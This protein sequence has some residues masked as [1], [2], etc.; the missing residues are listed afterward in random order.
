VRRG[1]RAAFGDDAHFGAPAFSAEYD[2]NKPVTVS[3]TVT[4]FEWTNP[5][6]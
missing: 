5:H 1:G 3:G 2:E 6:V 4:K